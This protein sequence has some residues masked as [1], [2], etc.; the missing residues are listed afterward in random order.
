MKHLAMISAICL[1]ISSACASQKSMNPVANT[2]LIEEQALRSGI[3]GTVLWF[4]GNQMPTIES[5]PKKDPARAVTRTLHFYQLTN[6]NQVVETDGFFIKVGTELVAKVETDQDGNFTVA[7]P[8]GKYSMFSQEEEGLWA[9]L[10]EGNGD[11]NP[12]VV[13]EG[14]MTLLTFKI[15]YRAAY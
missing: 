1:L 6:R 7:L 14:E 13:K 8:P 9:N 5:G 12:V 11:I 4:E 10:F 2:E 15:N 3:S